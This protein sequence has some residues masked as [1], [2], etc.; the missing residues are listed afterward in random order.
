MIILPATLVTLI[1]AL[2]VYVV[3]RYTP[4]VGR[5]FEEQP[6]F[7]PL[8]VAPTPGGEGVKFSTE[9]GY[10]LVGTYFSARAHPRAGVLVFCHEFLSDR[11]SY[12]PYLDGFRDIGFD[13][14][15]F[16][17]RNHGE[18]ASDAGYKPLQWVTDHEVRDLEA[19]LAFLRSRSDHTAAGFG[20]F[21]LSRGG[22]AALL[23]ASQSP[24]VWGVVTDGAFPTR[25]T[26]L[27]YILRWAEIYVVNPRVRH[28]LP[29]WI[30]PLV[31]WAGRVRSQRRLRCKYPDV[32]SA[33][34]AL[35]PR[36]WLS[37]HGEKDAYIGPEI[38]RGLF[39]CAG[40]PKELWIVPEAKH[41]RCREMAPELYTERVASFIQ[42]FAPAL[43]REPAGSN[44]EEGMVERDRA[45]HR[46]SNE[47]LS[48]SDA[49]ANATDLPASSLSG[50]Y[51]SPAS[52]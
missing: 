36:P 44:A 40:E 6:L 5:I 1:V 4:I 11:W 22:N 43:N 37:I 29:P 42:R 31:G 27:A 18:S 30:F 20:L 45:E 13:V 21:G 3:A 48:T 12:A 41:N 34:A 51:V 8:V 46:T 47:R 24:D 10:E 23:V 16:D 38:A 52:G 15:T 14:F 28:L 49:S 25:G 39:D 17:F 19:A 2:H 9:D 26:M 33:V 32:E 35:A 7:I 50:Y